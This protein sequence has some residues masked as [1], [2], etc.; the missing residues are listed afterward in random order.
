MIA[1]V[2]PG[3]GSIRE[4]SDVTFRRRPA[5]AAP[6]STFKAQYAGQGLIIS[7]HTYIEL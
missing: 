6:M 7:K 1:L 3:A 4:P 2:I 5:T